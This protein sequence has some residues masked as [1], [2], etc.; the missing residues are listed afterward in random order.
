MAIYD[1][2]GVLPAFSSSVYKLLGDTASF[3]EDVGGEGV[4]KFDPTFEPS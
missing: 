4:K 1:N 2:S 3:I